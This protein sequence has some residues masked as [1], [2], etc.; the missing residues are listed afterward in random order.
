MVTGRPGDPARRCRRGRS[1]RR[2]SSAS[3]AL[4]RPL[5]VKLGVDP[6]R[7]DLHAGSAV[8]LRKLRQFQE[9]GT[10]RGADRRRLHGAGRR[11]VRARSETRPL[12]V[13]GGGRGQ[14]RAYSRPGGQVLDPGGPRFGTTREWLEPMGMAGRAAPDGVHHG[15]ADARTRRLR[16]ALRAGP[17]D[18]DRWSSCTR[19]SRAMDSVAVEADVELGG[20]DQT[21][22]LLDGSGPAARVRPG[23]AGRAH[24]RRCSSAPTACRR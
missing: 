16:H 10:R 17:A 24:A 14:R 21:F 7:P 6:S 8:V 4:G 19:S 1:R 3:C 9:R 5:R 13:R 15:R 22:N 20:T 18:L 11:S 23:A 2:S 12:P